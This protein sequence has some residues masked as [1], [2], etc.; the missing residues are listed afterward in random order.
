MESI[1][2][3]NVNGKRVIVRVDFNVPIKNGEVVDDT[4]IVGA[5]KTIKYLVDNNS[6]VILLS[7]L[8]RVDSQEDK[9]KNTLRPVAKHL[10]TLIN[11]PIY[12]VPLTRGELLEKT[13]ENMSNGEIVIVENTRYEDYPKKLESSCDEILSK[14]WANLGDI[15][16]LDAF[17]S[18]HRCHA[19]TYGISKFL[20]SYSGFL[21]DEEVDM[22][23]K[24]MH[25]KKT[26]ILGG[27]KVDDKI[28]VIDNLVNT[29]D[30]VL[31]GGAMCFTF[32][33]AKGLSVGSSIVSDDKIDYCKEM[34]ENH[35]DKIY[36]PV[37]VVTQNGIKLVEDMN[38]DDVGYDIGPKTIQKYEK[39]LSKSPFVLWNGPLGKYED[40]T[41]VDGT[42]KIME[43]LSE[44]K[45][46]TMLAGGDITGAAK[47]LKL[48]FKYISTGGGSTLEYLEGKKFKT[49]ERLT[50]ENK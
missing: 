11:T 32:L 23:E 34:L 48:K 43:Y 21:V 41:Y 3:V 18:A 45:I 8:G 15:F 35:S 42:K 17:G 50:G 16:V 28:G 9:D 5:L 20:P 40:A 1:K 6:K 2:N 37:D 22:I 38:K 33:K 13:V 39:V 19:S 47:S 36:L 44:N 24:A 7:H 30:A 46:T 4:R 26:L 49:L 10:S 31:L 14:Y 25:Q 12:F 27:S 29:S